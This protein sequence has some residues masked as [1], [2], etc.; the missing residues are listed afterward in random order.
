MKLAE[1]EEARTAPGAMKARQAEIDSRLTAV[2]EEK[3]AIAR[4]IFESWYAECQHVI[5][6]AERGLFLTLLNGIEDSMNEFQTRTGTASP[7]GLTGGLFHKGHVAGLT[8]SE[9]SPEWRG[10][11]RWYAGRIG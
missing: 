2:G 3:K 10:G 4:R 8:A 11:I 1:A 5:R 9:R 7:N 6:A